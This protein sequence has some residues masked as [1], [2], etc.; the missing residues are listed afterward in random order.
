MN[1]RENIVCTWFAEPLDKDTNVVIGQMIDPCD[2][3]ENYL[4]AVKGAD[5]QNHNLWQLPNFQMVSSLKA[6]A[7]GL[8][9]RFKIWG[10]VGNGP[11]REWFKS[12]SQ[13]PN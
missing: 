6:S 11:I 10:R 2:N 1:D 8:R 5:G 9:L 7:K 4:E 12:R 13:S 3:L